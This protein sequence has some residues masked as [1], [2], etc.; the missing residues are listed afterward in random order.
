MARKPAVRQPPVPHMP[1][2]DDPLSLHVNQI[3]V[4]A[5]AVPAALLD[6][7]HQFRDRIGRA[8]SVVAHRHDIAAAHTPRLVHGIIQTIIRLG[9]PF[10]G[11]LPAVSLIGSAALSRLTVM[12]ALSV[13]FGKIPDNFQRSVLR[14]PVHDNDLY[15]RVILLS[16]TVQRYL[17]LLFYI[18]SCH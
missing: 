7:P 15:V 2:A 17:C 3:R 5:D 13:L 11:K 10:D 8:E 1:C 12:T 14:L 6:R 18:I 16:D 9:D 4:R